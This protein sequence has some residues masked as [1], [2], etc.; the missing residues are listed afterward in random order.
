[1]RVT[2]VA[3]LFAAGVRQ[4]LADGEASESCHLQLHGKGELKSAKPVGGLTL[5]EE[6][7]TS[8]DEEM[9]SDLVPNRQT[10]WFREC[11]P[12]FSDE[13]YGLKAPSLNLENH[14]SYELYL[15]PSGLCQSFLFCAYQGCTPPKKRKACAALQ[16]DQIRE[17][18]AAPE[19]LTAH[20]RKCPPDN[21]PF[22]VVK[23]VTVADII[24]AVEFA[25][26][27]GRSISIKVS[28]LN[29]AGSSLFYGSV[30]I[31]MANYQ[32]YSKSNIIECG[33]LP[34]PIPT[35]LTNQKAVCKLA[36][37]RGKKAVVR[38]GGGENWNEV[39]SAVY[40]YQLPTQTTRRY[41]VVGGSA[42]TLSAA[43]GW[44]QGGGL[45]GTTGMRIFGIGVDQVL[46]IE[47][48]LSNGKHVRFMPSTWTNHSN[49]TGKIYPQT[50]TVSGECN[51][52]PVADESKWHWEPC[53]DLGL[54]VTFKDLWFAVRGGGGGTYGIVTSVY[55]QL[56]EQVSQ[57]L[58][59]DYYFVYTLP[60]VLSSC[61]QEACQ[62]LVRSLWLNFVRD[63]FHPKE[64]FPWKDDSKFCGTSILNLDIFLG[65][66]FI[67][68][69]GETAVF[70]FIGVWQSFVA[71]YQE[72]LK[73]VG[74]SE[75]D[76]AKLQKDDGG[77]FAFSLSADWYPASLFSSP[78][79]P[80]PAHMN[81][82]PTELPDFPTPATYPENY[83]V[84]WTALVP[85]E[86]LYLDR[87]IPTL[88]ALVKGGLGGP[89][90]YVLGGQLAVSDD[91]LTS[92]PD[93]QRK[94][95][96]MLFLIGGESVESFLRGTFEEYIGGNSSTKAFPGGSEYLHISPIAYGPLKDD[97]TKACPDSLSDFEKAK[98][99]LSL[100]E[101]VWGTEQLA[102]LE[103]VK[104]KAD[105][106]HL[107]QCFDCVGFKGIRRSHR[108]WKPKP[109]F[110][111][112]P[113]YAS[114]CYKWLDHDPAGDV[115]FMKKARSELLEALKHHYH[116]KHLVMPEMAKDAP[117]KVKVQATKLKV[118]L[119]VLSS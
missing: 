110:C 115:N 49:V 106:E 17:L 37:A 84:D 72:A 92:V 56:H 46:E 69:H 31:N 23:A 114:T 42:G 59:L 90:T 10:A 101:S 29:Y 40:W 119:P 63:F 96:F 30:N 108:P 34:E 100:Q 88:L 6:T 45:S 58:L 47:M 62:D 26:H 93:F 13:G 103:E 113:S 48:V 28:G 33:T 77:I 38:V 82:Y 20:L 55:Y 78:S 105:P 24:E 5:G 39:Y 107:F 52:N 32:K 27:T 51:Q 118:T 73:A 7:E 85:V 65:G 50:L 116:L 89:S 83:V 75:E 14:S 21:L 66:A 61:T 12:A 4:F 74:L 95:G 67:I 111:L 43:G 94:A 11:V 98:K 102:K 54:P 81:K 71:G 53:D 109:M 36:A 1:M 18:V 60:A 16:E 68:C 87:G 80:W 3:A 97:W 104:E 70:T 112:K 99:C 86:W 76:V 117:Y 2:V 35:S 44:L 19:K 64:E 57:Q 91:G 8:G 9:E 22:S 79:F 15:K 25:R 41:L